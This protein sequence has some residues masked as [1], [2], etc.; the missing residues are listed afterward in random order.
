MVRAFVTYIIMLIVKMSFSIY[1]ITGADAT[2]GKNAG[3]MST[4]G[5]E[6]NNNIKNIDMQANANKVNVG[7]IGAIDRKTNNNIKNTDI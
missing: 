4:I 6:V 1:D 3:D 5:E 7:N 2:M